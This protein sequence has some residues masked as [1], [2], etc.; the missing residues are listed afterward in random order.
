[1][2]WKNVCKQLILFQNQ[3]TNDYV[4]TDKATREV[5]GK[6]DILNY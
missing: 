5:A 3:A 6:I 1:M 2:W 4:E